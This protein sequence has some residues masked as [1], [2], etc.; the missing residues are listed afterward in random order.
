IT[1]I[2]ATRIAA[3]RHRIGGRRARE[4]YRTRRH[5]VEGW[6]MPKHLFTARD[7]PDLQ[8]EPSARRHTDDAENSEVD[9]FGLMAAPTG[10]PTACLQHASARVGRDDTMWLEIRAIE[11]YE[12][13]AR[14]RRSSRS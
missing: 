11:F 14:T 7:H 9:R 3:R 1:R 4:A 2:R 8:A 6:V 13:Y 5:A 10:R 12:P